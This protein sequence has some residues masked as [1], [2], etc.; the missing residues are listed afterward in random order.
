MGRD[1]LA[2]GGNE[3]CTRLKLARKLIMWCVLTE[4]LFLKLKVLRKFILEIAMLSAKGAFLLVFAQ[5]NAGGSWY[6]SAF[7]PQAAVCQLV[8]QFPP[9]Q[10]KIRPE[11]IA[12][13][14]VA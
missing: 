8:C 11:N 12:D 7:V 2:G 6:K 5:H 9:M 14:I 1:H 10:R 13:I 3:W 4:V